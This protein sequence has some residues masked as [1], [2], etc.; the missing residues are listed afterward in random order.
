MAIKYN[1]KI[2]VRDT[3]TEL[4]DSTATNSLQDRIFCIGNRENEISVTAW[5][6]NEESDWEIIETR[7]IGP[8]MYDTIEL[9]VNHFFECKLIG[10]TIS[11]QAAGIVDAF[12]I[13]TPAQ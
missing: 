5:G 6:R 2:S 4:I 13:Y 3:D 12:F 1:L 7:T 9:D 8:H 11:S 10:N